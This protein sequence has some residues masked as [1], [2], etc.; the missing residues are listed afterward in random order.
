MCLHLVRLRD[1]HVG[2]A[3]GPEVVEYRCGTIGIVALAQQV[4]Q[5][6]DRRLADAADRTLRGRVVRANRLDR[7]AD[8]LESNRLFGTGRKEIDDAAA[9][10]ELTRFVDR[11]LTGVARGREQI[12][13]VGGGDVLPRLQRQ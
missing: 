1:E 13:E 12:A 8:E 9:N 6:N 10:A 11:V 2:P 3:V 4:L 7:V 5:W